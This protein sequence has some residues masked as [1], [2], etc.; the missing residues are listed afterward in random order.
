M[1]IKISLISLMGALKAGP[2]SVDALATKLGRSNAHEFLDDLEELQTTLNGMRDLGLEV[3]EEFTVFPA[4]SRERYGYPDLVPVVKGANPNAKRK[5]RK[6]PA[7]PVMR[8]DGSL[9]VQYWPFVA[10]GTIVPPEADEPVKYDGRFDVLVTL[11]QQALEGD[12]VNFG[13]DGPF[14]GWTVRGTN[15]AIK[16]IPPGE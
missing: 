11:V 13:D 9:A 5:P 15:G 4:R 12:D 10:L 6:N 3:A 7:K 16:L 2:L 14:A 1:A 8:K